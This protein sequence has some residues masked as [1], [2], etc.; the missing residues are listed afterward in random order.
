MVDLRGPLSSEAAMSQSKRF[1]W[2]RR[3]ACVAALS[4]AFASEGRTNTRSGVPLVDGADAARVSL[5]VEA[6]ACKPGFVEE[7]LNAWLASTKNSDFE[8]EYAAMAFEELV[9]FVHVLRDIA[10]DFCV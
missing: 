8:S 5:M 1:L 7:M 2:G 6:G 4:L 10:Q 3:L 9:D